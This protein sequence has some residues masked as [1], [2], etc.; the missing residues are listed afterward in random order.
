MLD[1]RMLEPNDETCLKCKFKLE[2]NTLRGEKLLE[3]IKSA[4]FEKWVCGFETLNFNILCLN[5]TFLR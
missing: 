5:S 2:Q 1:D 4:F 3:L